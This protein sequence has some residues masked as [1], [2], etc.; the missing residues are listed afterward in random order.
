MTNHDF[1]VISSPFGWATKLPG[2]AC[3]HGSSIGRFREVSI[4]SLTRH[5]MRCLF[6][7]AS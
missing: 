7:Y 6:G 3:R 1:M 2:P 4:A 5:V